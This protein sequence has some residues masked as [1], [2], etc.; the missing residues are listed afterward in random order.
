MVG[1]LTAALA[2]A[3]VATR[4][5]EVRAFMRNRVRIRAGSVALITGEMLEAFLRAG[6]PALEAV[7]STAVV[8]MVAAGGTKD[9]CAA[10]S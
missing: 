4:F 3:T 8:R 5:T 10:F 6:I 9:R 2:T 7:A 1:S